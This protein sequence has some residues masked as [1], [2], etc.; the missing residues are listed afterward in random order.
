MIAKPITMSRP[1]SCDRA[2]CL[3]QPAARDGRVDVFTGKGDGL[4]AL[5]PGA[6]GSLG[7]PRQCLRVDILPD[8]RQFAISNGNGEDP[9]VFERPIRGFDFPPRETDN[10]NP[11][12]LC[13][14]L[15]RLWERSFHRFE[16]LLGQ[17]PLEYVTEWR[18]QKAM[19]LLQQ[20]DKSS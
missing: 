2:Q 6:R 5:E 16:E 4:T 3:G 14:E 8:L 13:Y 17:T 20:R 7:G 1:G 18:M 15:G 9:T 10:H 19:Q 12:S 11:V